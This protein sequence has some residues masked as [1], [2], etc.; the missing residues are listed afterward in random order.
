M[1]RAAPAPHD[2]ATRCGIDTVEI[3]RIERLVAK[4][5]ATQLLGLFSAQEIAD[6]GE[7]AGRGASLAARFAA[8][9]ACLKLFPREA[10]LGELEPADFSVV[11]DGYGAPQASVSQRAAGVLARN[12]IGSIALSL[13]HDRVSASAVALALPRD[14]RVPLS[15]R[16]LYRFA[17]FRRRIVLDNLRL[18]FGDAAPRAE[19][20][21][22]AQAHYAHLWR[23]GAEFLRF[24]CTSAERKAAQ[25]RV[26]NV[27]VFANALERGKGILVLT[28]HFG[29]W[30]VATVAGLRQFP[31]MHGRIHFV[32]RPIKPR[33]LDWFVNSRFRKAGFGVLPKRGSLDA[34]LD[35]LA[36]GDAVVF[37]FDQHASPPDGIDVDFFGHKAWTFRSLAL[38]ALASEAQVLPAASW[39]ESEGSHVLRFEEPVVL[40]R[41][42]DAGEEIR[43]ATRAYNAALERLILRHPEQWYWVHRRWKR[44]SRRRSHRRG[45]ALTD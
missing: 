3:A 10:A 16:L 39:R 26:E 5:D 20:E 22:L 31:Q 44:A 40:E 12:R 18:V 4:N 43:L 38:I 11:R 15:G 2:S 13:S 41:A 24:R 32:R 45:E 1:R 35:R 36:A 28:G 7:G 6:A 37:A 21:R 30:E 33:W 19:I 29:N 34:I 9:E 27:G 17:P 8:K 14:A 23:L 25:V 42:A